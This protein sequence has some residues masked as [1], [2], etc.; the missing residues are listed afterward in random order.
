MLEEKLLTLYENDEDRPAVKLFKEDYFELLSPQA[1]E[2]NYKQEF[3]TNGFVRTHSQGRRSS[4]Q[5][6]VKL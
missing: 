5:Q 1:R 2:E 6:R 4:R 3:A